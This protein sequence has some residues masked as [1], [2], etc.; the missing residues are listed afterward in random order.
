MKTLQ[1]SNIWFAKTN[2]T[3]FPNITIWLCKSRH[4][5]KSE[6]IFSLVPLSSRRSLSWL[7]TPSGHESNECSAGDRRPYIA[8]VILSRYAQYSLYFYATLYTYTFS[9]KKYQIRFSCCVYII[10]VVHQTYKSSVL[11]IIKYMISRYCVRTKA[12][13]WS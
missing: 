3:Y 5:S 1:F 7:S 2:E 6:F 12:Y 4:Q 8:W 13:P 10:I 9:F 11:N